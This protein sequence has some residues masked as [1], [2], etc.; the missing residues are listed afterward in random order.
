M[1]LSSSAPLSSCHVTL[2]M[3]DLRGTELN[4]SLYA[5]DDGAILD[6]QF[7]DFSFPPPDGFDRIYFEK[8][9]L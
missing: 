9:L 8:N 2:Y 4:S 5:V 6:V 7:M 3:H 1:Y